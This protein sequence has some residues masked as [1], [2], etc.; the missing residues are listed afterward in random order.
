[1]E[2]DK[3]VSAAGN[4]RNSYDFGARMYNNRLGRW[5]SRDP[6]ENKYVSLSPYV[7]VANQP[8]VA[9]D[10]N[11][12][13]IVI[14]GNDSYQKAIMEML[15]ELAA[16]SSTAR[17]IIMNL[18]ESEKKVFIGSMDNYSQRDLAH[19]RQYPHA[20]KSALTG[21]GCIF[22]DLEYTEDDL[23][24][25]KDHASI[26]FTPSIS[27]IH[28]LVHINDYFQGVQ[29]LSFTTGEN[30]KD[31]NGEDVLDDFGYPYPAHENVYEM[32]AVQTTNTIRAEM[33]LGKDQLRYFYGEA[34]VYDMEFNGI[35]NSR[36]V[37]LPK[38]ER[39][40]YDEA[41]KNNEPLSIEEI[42]D[43]FIEKG[44]II[45]N[46]NMA[47]EEYPYGNLEYRYIEDKRSGS[48]PTKTLKKDSGEGAEERTQNRIK[49]KGK[50]NWIPKY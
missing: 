29:D 22:F 12:R 41:A 47:R 3:E 8:I 46:G 28:E 16:K 17:E 50:E 35:K 20:K 34:L 7:F 43:L 15:M 11:G 9:T 25:G 14:V 19:D 31:S 2:A 24:E 5:M 32:R 49:R 23:N 48:Q 42:M 30:V 37:P 18:I 21:N 6:F 44:Y 36:L 13:E 33:G 1:M 45:E 39:F 40:D 26:H 4:G 38:D 10:P 27:L